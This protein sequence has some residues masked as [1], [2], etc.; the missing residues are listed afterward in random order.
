MIAPDARVGKGRPTFAA[1]H[2]TMSANFGFAALATA[3]QVVLS[4]AS[5]T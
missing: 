2:V 1:R 4:M 5:A 3:P